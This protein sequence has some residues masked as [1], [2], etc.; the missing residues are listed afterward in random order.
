M[1][2]NEKSHYRL[3]AR[4]CLQF[5]NLQELEFRGP[6]VLQQLLS[7]LELLEASVRPLVLD[8]PCQAALPTL[9]VHALHCLHGRGWQPR[10]DVGVGHPHSHTSGCDHCHEK[11]SAAVGGQQSGNGTMG[12]IQ[13]MDM[14]L[15]VHVNRQR[16]RLE[17]AGS[18]PTEVGMDK[19]SIYHRSKGGGRCAPHSA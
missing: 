15:L 5:L 16:R 11:S 4:A 6:R 14:A 7:I 1:E 8:L 2:R 17:V 18:K 3:R 10:C 13:A 9:R 12:H 19:G